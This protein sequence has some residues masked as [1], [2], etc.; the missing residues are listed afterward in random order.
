MSEIIAKTQAPR[1]SPAASGA[2]RMLYAAL[3][4]LHSASLQ[5]VQEVRILFS[6][7]A[8]LAA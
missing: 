8:L 7:Q 4:G 2:V 6:S 5:E 3:G 1:K